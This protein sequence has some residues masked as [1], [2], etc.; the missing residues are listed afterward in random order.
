ME[1]RG[2]RMFLMV[3]ERVENA[4]GPRER[5]LGPRGLRC[6]N[7]SVSSQLTVELADS[8]TDRTCRYLSG[9]E[10]SVCTF[11]TGAT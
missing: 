8:G 5:S 11:S 2:V 9:S 10:S 7:W 6:P 3:P 4:R 1:A